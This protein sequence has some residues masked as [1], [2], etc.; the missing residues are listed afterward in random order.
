MPLF[1]FELLPFF[2]MAD[3][4]KNNSDPKT[5]AAE[6]E[7]PPEPAAAK[8][9]NS[10]EFEAGR[11][12]VLGANARGPK[13]TKKRKLEGDKVATVNKEGIPM[14]HR[15]RYSHLLERCHDHQDH[16]VWLFYEIQT[17]KLLPKAMKALGK[18]Q[19]H[20]RERANGPMHQLLDRA[21]AGQDGWKRVEAEQFLRHSYLA[22][23]DFDSTLD[24]DD[25]TVMID[26]D[27][28][29]GDTDIVDDDDDEDSEIPSIKK[30]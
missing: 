1:L 20:V 6:K 26:D 16:A 29:G 23:F 14:N 19:V 30:M 21:R 3:T 8:T 12:H 17:R 9:S 13:L 25:D 15:G 4:K 28:E 5:A 10:E 24:E 22:L 18:C 11:S 27:D 2:K 7:K